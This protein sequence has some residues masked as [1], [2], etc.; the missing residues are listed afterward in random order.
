MRALISDGEKDRR[1]LERKRAQRRAAGMME[2]ADY[3]ET[4]DQRRIQAGVMHG[5]GMSLR[6]IGAALGVSHIRVCQDPA[7]VLRVCPR[8]PLSLILRQISDSLTPQ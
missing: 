3:E 1:E 5:Q 6:A 8:Y 4:A 7:G 2:R